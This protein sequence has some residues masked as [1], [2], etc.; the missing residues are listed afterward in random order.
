MTYDEFIKST[1]QKYPHTNLDGLE[2]ALWYIVK[3]NWDMAHSITQGINTETASWIHAYLHRAEG[4]L[5]NAC[6]WYNRARK[7]VCYDSLEGELDN[8]VKSIF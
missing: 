1:K 2:L 8:I 7:E 3:E 6:Y 4:D 5:N